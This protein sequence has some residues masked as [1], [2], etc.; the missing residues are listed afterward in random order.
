MKNYHVPV[1]I[2]DISFIHPRVRETEYCRITIDQEYQ[3]HS[4]TITL[5]PKC[6]KYIQIYYLQT[7]TLSYLHRLYCGICCVAKVNNQF[8][9]FT[10]L[11]HIFSNQIPIILILIHVLHMTEGSIFFSALAKLCLFVKNIKVEVMWN[12]SNILRPSLR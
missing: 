1:Y 12:N 11:F 7:A 5:F 4:N 10:T 9:P 3:D 8:Y 6:T 2:R